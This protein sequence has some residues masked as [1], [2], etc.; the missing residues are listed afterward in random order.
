MATAA[1]PPRFQLTRQQWLICGI[2]A[3]GFCFD[4][5]ELLMLPLILRPALSE[6]LGATPGTPLFNQ[7]AGLLFYVPALFGGVFGL[8]GGYLT[9]RFGRRRVLVASIL[10]YAIAAFASGF[11]TS[12]ELLLMWRCFVFVGVCVEFV[13]GIAWL[14][15]LFPEPVLREKV[16]GF[17]QAFSSLG[18][19]LVTGAYKLSVNIAPM[20]PEIAGGHSAW[21]Y[22]LISGVLPALPL[23]LVR[24]WLPESPAWAERR[25]AGTLK[26]P[27]LREIFSPKLRRVTIVATLLTAVSYA[28]AF[29][30]LQ[31]NPRI[32]PGLEGVA[33]QPPKV[34]E[35]TVSNVQFSQELGGLT[36]RILMAFLAVYIVSRQRLLRLFLVPAAVLMPLLYLQAPDHGWA[37]LAIGVFAGGLLTVGQFNF[38]GNYL[39]QVYPTHL[40]GTGESFAANVGG[41]MIGTSAAYVATQLANVMPGAGPAVK[42][43]HS[44]ALVALTVGII[45]IVASFWLPEP[46]PNQRN[47]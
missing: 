8:L 38:W 12:V 30:A 46:D 14:A 35:N 36:G 28:F 22:T 33:G 44:C 41:R 4:I 26:R 31:Q 11:A 37:F 23:I 21:R 45:G 34:I 17:T 25:A 3:L 6:L 2:A 9:D 39:P 15:E 7:W 10:I 32:V 27:S 24:P 5:Y 20:L 42:L 16:L 40:R 29:G 47:E 18:G 13:A 19:F 1:A 43:A